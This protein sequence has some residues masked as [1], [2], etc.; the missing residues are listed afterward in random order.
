MSL[1]EPL[2]IRNRNVAASCQLAGLRNR[3]PNRYPPTENRCL[4]IIIAEWIAYKLAACGYDIAA[5]SR[6]V[7][8]S[9]AA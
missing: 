8:A 4:G 2:K 1:A 3:L 9:H 6:M 7:A 5:R